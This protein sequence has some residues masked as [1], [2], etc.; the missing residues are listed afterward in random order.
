MDQN[1]FNTIA[2]L[3]NVNVARRFG[4]IKAILF[5][6]CFILDPS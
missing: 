5:M 6:Y 4:K 3:L 1:D 2:W